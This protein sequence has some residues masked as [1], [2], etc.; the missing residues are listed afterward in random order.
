MFL[1]SSV[2]IG[3]RSKGLTEGFCTGLSLGFRSGVSMPENV[4]SFYKNLG[5]I[6]LREGLGS[7]T[8]LDGFRAGSGEVFS[9]LLGLRLL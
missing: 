7:S 9:R 8:L 4:L 2:V 1:I 6:V 5:L 3:I